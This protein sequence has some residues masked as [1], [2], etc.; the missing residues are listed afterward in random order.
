MV[1]PYA[2]TSFSPM[3]TDTRPSVADGGQTALERLKHAKQ[4]GK[5]FSLILT[6]CHMPGID[7]FMLVERVRQE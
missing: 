4:E 1:T 7:G 5:P 3:G 6:D 2:N